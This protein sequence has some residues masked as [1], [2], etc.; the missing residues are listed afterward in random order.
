MMTIEGIE[1]VAIG[2][3]KYTQKELSP[4]VQYEMQLSYY[5]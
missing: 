1:I 4:A 3:I 5:Y 2:R